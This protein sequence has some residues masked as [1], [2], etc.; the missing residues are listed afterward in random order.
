[1]RSGIQRKVDD[2]GRVVIPAGI[3]RSLGIR[4]GDALEVSVQGEEVV[5]SKPVDQCVFCGS[6][7]NLRTFRAKA[8]CA[9]CASGVGTLDSGAETVATEETAEEVTLPDWAKV[10]AAQTTPPPVQEAGLRV[11][12]SEGVSRAE[13]HELPASTT[14]W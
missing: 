12:R 5:L 13:R 6:G 1:M 8:V 10:A 9:P 11:V 2:L 4:E 3:R 7:R 14:A